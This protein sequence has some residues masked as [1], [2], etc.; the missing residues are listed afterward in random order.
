MILAIPNAP[1]ARHSKMIAH[2]RMSFLRLTLTIGTT[3]RPLSRI[4]QFLSSTW[5]TQHSTPSPILRPTR[6][7]IPQSKPTTAVH[8]RVSWQAH[9]LLTLWDASR[10]HRWRPPNKTVSCPSRELPM[11]SSLAKLEW[12][13]PM[14]ALTIRRPSNGDQLSPN[15]LSNAK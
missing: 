3:P 14:T 1:S 2:A 12:L 15:F 5:Q 11:A 10:L 4:A 6:S 7:S 13:S 9:P 8:G